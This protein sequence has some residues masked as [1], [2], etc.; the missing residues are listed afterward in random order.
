M[1]AIPFQISEPK[2]APVPRIAQGADRW[3]LFS[4]GFRPFFLFGAVWA[5]L[6][7]ALWMPAYLGQLALPIAIEPLDWHIHELLYGY[8]S[9]IVAG[10]LLTAIPNWTGR[11]PLAGRPLM[12]LFALWAAGRIAM[13]TSAWSGPLVAATVDFA[14][15]PVF[16]M[17]CVRE[18]VAGKNWRNL[19]IVALALLLSVGNAVFHAEV[20]TYGTSDI[21]RRLGVAAAIAM[22]LLVGG[23]IIPSFTRNWLGRAPA[24]PMPAAFSRF[25]GVSILVAVVGLG[26]W[27][28]HP[29]DRITAV[30]LVAAGILQAWRL[31]RWV[32]YR[33]ARD[34]LVLVLH[35]AYGFVALGFLAMAAA[36]AWPAVVPIGAGMHLWTAGAIAGMTLAVMTRATLGHTGRELVATRGTSL[37][38]VL[39]GIATAARVASALW[40]TA[41]LLL[42]ATAAWIGAFGGFVFVYGPMLVRKRKDRT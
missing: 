39:A 3:A 20:A 32:G 4:Y 24:G 41:S 28:A 13:S 40:P 37:I 16:A 1:P 19:R 17:F 21:G 30:L 8:L 9:A 15:L 36:V 18:V 12:G 35:V 2:R 29:G 31:A 11:L 34:S 10:F 5:A 25:D 23:R 14:F 27:T 26:V 7:V 42:V 22:I 33:A 6:A 38:Y